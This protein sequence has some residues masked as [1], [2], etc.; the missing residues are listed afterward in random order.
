[1]SLIES[2]RRSRQMNRSFKE[3]IKKSV[4]DLTEAK[5]PI[6][7][8]THKCSGQEKRYLYIK[9]QC[10]NCR[11]A[12]NKMY[13]AISDGMTKEEICEKLNSLPSLPIVATGGCKR[14]KSIKV[15]T[16]HKCKDGTVSGIIEKENAQRFLNADQYQNW[17]RGEN[18]EVILISGYM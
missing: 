2:G 16:L 17:I 9:G 11:T 12:E 10:S 8:R 18:V 15:T 13:D 5:E 1:M 6:V 4:K 7:I 14:I 3:Y